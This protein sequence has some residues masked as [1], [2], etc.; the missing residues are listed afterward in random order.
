M[1][2]QPN[3]SG[4]PTRKWVAATV[5][6]V[7]GLLTTWVATGQWT[8]ELSGVAVTLLTQRIVAYI[9]PNDDTVGGV[10]IKK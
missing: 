3:K 7:G 6:A 1:N 5:I 4:M 9:V 2:A 8:R 10:P